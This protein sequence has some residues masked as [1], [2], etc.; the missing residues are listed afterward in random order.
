VQEAGR[1]SSLQCPYH[2]WTYGLNGALKGAPRSKREPCFEEA[3]LGLLPV[4]VETFGPLVFANLSPEP[5]PLLDHL[6]SVPAW[7]DSAGIS[8]D[9]YE[10]AF[11]REYELEANWKVFAENSLECYH[12]PTV[13]PRIG[14]FMHIGPDHFKVTP[15]GNVIQMEAPYRQVPKPEGG[16]SPSQTPATYPFVF[17]NLQFFTFEDGTDRVFNVQTWVPDG[18]DRTLLRN[19]YFFGNGTSSA[20]RDE[21]SSFHEDLVYE[22]KPVVEAVH[23]GMRSGVLKEGRLLIDSEHGIRHFNELV[24]M[25]LGEAA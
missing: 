21:Y 14:Q 2:G 12:C 22:D 1:H 13:H 6:G 3:A 18:P 23:F 19:D 11:R 4:T 16:H 20:F 25:A 8:L 15:N 5:R 7:L 17:P 24:R 10:W 9:N